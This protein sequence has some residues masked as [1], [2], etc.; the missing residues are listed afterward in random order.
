[1]SPEANGKTPLPPNFEFVPPRNDEQSVETFMAQWDDRCGL[2][3]EQFGQ[4]W[5]ISADNLGDEYPYHNAEHS[6]ENLWVAMEWVDFFETVGLNCNRKVVI[7]AVMYHDDGYHVD[8]S[9]LGYET[10]EDYSAARFAKD[11]ELY[12]YTGDEVILGIEAIKATT[13]G[14]M[15]RSPEALAVVLGDLWNVGASFNK[16]FLPKTLAF[17]DETKTKVIGLGKNFSDSEFVKES[18]STLTDYVWALENQT[19]CNIDS[20]LNPAVD[21]LRQLVRRA[22]NE[23]HISVNSYLSALNENIKNRLTKLLG[24]HTRS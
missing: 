22:A 14:E 7:G 5:S 13:R 11:S 19:I 8:H 1:M 15:P 4:M 10:K 9:D 18:I 3:T 20:F 6:R 2:T 23:D 16:Y 17:A 24:R 12:D 21:N